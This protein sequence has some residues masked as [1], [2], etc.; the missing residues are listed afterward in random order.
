MARAALR[1][2]RGDF[3]KARQDIDEAW[4]IALRNGMRM[5]QADCHLE[6][7]WLQLALTEK[8]AAASSLA[9]FSKEAREMGYRRREGEVEKLRQL[10]KS[11]DP[12]MPE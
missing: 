2:A 3:D 11:S 8:G 1:R 9:T 4:K 5:Y 6:Y 7:A 10:L 12:A